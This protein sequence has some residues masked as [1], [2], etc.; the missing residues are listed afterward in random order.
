MVGTCMSVGSL[1]S[2]L[3]SIKKTTISELPGHGA[4]PAC[5][6][7]PEEGNMHEGVCRLYI[8]IYIYICYPH[9]VWL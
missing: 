6:A 2:K 1:N 7:R 3:Q 9:L 8:Y 5:A 4:W